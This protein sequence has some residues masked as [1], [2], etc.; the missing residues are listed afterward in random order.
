MR[1]QRPPLPLIIGFGAFLLVLSYLIVAS[2]TRPSVLEFAPTPVGIRPTGGPEGDTVTIDARDPA[3]WQ[4]YSLRRGVISAPDTAD[5]DLGFRRFHAITSGSAADAGV[6]TFEQVRDMATAAFTETVFA[7]DTVHLAL[8]RWYRYGFVTHLL[9]PN[10]HVFLLRTRSLGPIKLEF[11][12]YYCPGV[13][14]GCLTFRWA[15]LGP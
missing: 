8:S 1:T 11:L 3:R 2:L 14:P 7:R 12:S 6:V 4:F 13:Q 10:G 5:W 15:P 9:R